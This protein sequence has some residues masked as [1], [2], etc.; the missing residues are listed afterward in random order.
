MPEPQHFAPVREHA[1]PGARLCAGRSLDPVDGSGK[2][3]GVASQHGANADSRG[4][5]IQINSKSGLEGSKCNFAYAGSKFGSI[6]L[7]QSFALELVEHG[8]K[9]NAVCPGN[10]LDGPLW[11]D[12]KTGLFVQ[13][14]KAKKVPGA[15]IKKTELIE[16][17]KQWFTINYG[18][19]LPK[20]REL[21]EFMDKK[22][23]K[24]NGKWNNVVINYDDD[25]EDDD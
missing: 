17:F 24:Y 12:P 20:A 25:E 8:I 21:Y 14:L 5:I 4:D 2:N 23:G 10:F 18:K 7:V 9:V 3:P 6:G 16:V 22:F 15:K 1:H 13:Y 11:S 19:G